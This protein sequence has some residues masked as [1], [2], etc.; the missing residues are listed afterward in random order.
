MSPES[1]AG[2][3]SRSL[4]AQ[5]P[6]QF[7]EIPLQ[8]DHSAAAGHS[9]FTSIRGESLCG[10]WTVA[11]CVLIGWL[12]TIVLGFFSNGVHHDDDLVHFLMARWAWWYPKYLL[13]V[14]G[15]PG[16]TIP[17]AAAAWP[18]DIDVAW[19]ASRFLSA[20]VS[21]GVAYMAALLAYRSGAPHPWRAVAF[22]YLQPLFCVLGFT[23]LTEN[24]TAFYLVIAVLLLSR[25]RIVWAALLFSPALLTRHEAVIF[26][27]IW[28]SAL[29]WVGWGGAGRTGFPT[30]SNPRPLRRRV[31]LSAVL[32][33]WAPI[34][35]NVLFRVFLGAWPVSI[36]F[37][38]R[39]S[40]EYPPTGWSAFV[41][42]A[43]Y[44]VTP[45]IA[46]LAVVGAASSL[47]SLRCRARGTPSDR[48]AAAS[49]AL[50]VILPAAFFLVHAV[51]KATGIYAS[52]GYGR[53]MVAVSPFVAI[54]AVRGLDTLVGDV[55]GA[56]HRDIGSTPV[57][58]R[59]W[60]L[61]AFVWLVLFVAL[62]WERAVGRLVPTNVPS[63]WA[64]R[65]ILAGVVLLTAAAGF[66]VGGRWKRGVRSA[67]VL[68]M[69]IPA[70]CQFAVQV[71]PLTLRAAQIAA[72]SVVHELDRRQLS[73]R[74]IFAASGWFAYGLGLVENPRA[75]K[76]AVLLASMPTGT[77]LIWDAKYSESDYHGLRLD[78]VLSS[79]AYRE[80]KSAGDDPHGQRLAGYHLFEK[81]HETPIPQYVRPSYPRPMIGEGPSV[82][83]IFYQR[84]PSRPRA[85]A[86]VQVGN[87]L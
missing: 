16:F 54:L 72:A 31:V 83:G 5:R 17:M 53:F 24:F 47:S 21:A 11:A 34:A 41:P 86:R 66:V 58:R 9:D 39:G 74:P 68:A 67:W 51:I 29:A 71:R 26:V 77:I 45:L 33:L 37:Q 32:S 12:A 42:D 20:T 36:F 14:W 22:C 35:H 2:R 81:T 19:H 52:G 80:L 55:N 82:R 13:H 79:G 30:E 69:L 87:A 50:V 15:R 46:V 62:E 60:K 57:A 73:D 85:F 64:V 76:N 75:M 6:R 3:D 84:D 28:W 65:V 43:L 44:A 63:W 25:G 40:T 61:A 8:S 4:S 48:F 7:K 56:A 1:R 49:D 10:G 23:T 70:L 27:P 59:H 38:P 78:E 18:A